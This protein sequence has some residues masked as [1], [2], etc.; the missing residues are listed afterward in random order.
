MST[1][2]NWSS[3]YV[4][5]AFRKSKIFPLKVIL[6]I[7]FSEVKIIH[8]LL[9][10]KKIQGIPGWH[11][12]LAPAFGPGRDPGDPGSNPMSGSQ[13]M[14]PASPS[15]CGSGSLSLCLS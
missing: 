7:N 12:G 3:K 1:Y 4:Y 14:E 8:M 5:T 9:D 2:E 11:G 15:A 13:C 10:F 6:Q